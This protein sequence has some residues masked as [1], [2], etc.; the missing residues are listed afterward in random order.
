MKSKL[1]VLLSLT[2]LILLPAVLWADCTDLTHYTHW[3][4]KDSHTILFYR[5][6]RA[7]AVITLEGCEAQSNSSVRLITTY[8][9]ESDK[10]M[11]DNRE[12]SIMT[13]QIMN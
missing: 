9:C 13:L 11:I 3:V 10:I 5:G 6:N 4:L 2:A 12:C 8:V 7:L 1:S